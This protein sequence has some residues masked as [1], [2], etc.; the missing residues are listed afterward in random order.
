MEYC[1]IL[2]KSPQGAFE[3][4][5]Q[6]DQEKHKTQWYEFIEELQK[7]GVMH[8]GF[9][10]GDHRFVVTANGSNTKWPTLNEMRLCGYMVIRGQSVDEIKKRFL[11][12][13]ALHV[14]GEIEIY[15]VPQGEMSEA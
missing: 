6:E 15:P 9:P 11:D 2:L 7:Q 10:V 8:S 13:P 1:L 4:L 5:C 12:S 14:G 3:S